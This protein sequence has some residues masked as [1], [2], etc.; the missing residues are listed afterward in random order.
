METPLVEYNKKKKPENKIIEKV[1]EKSKEEKIVEKKIKE[2]KEEEII[3]KVEEPSPRDDSSKDDTTV[4]SG[5]P[6][7][8]KIVEKKEI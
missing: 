1:S 8:E 6:K 7:K 5:E 4:P 2:V 3:K